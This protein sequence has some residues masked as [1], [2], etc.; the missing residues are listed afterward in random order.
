MTA[1]QDSQQK[2]LQRLVDQIERLEEEKRA[3]AADI[4]DKYKEATN[5]GFVAKQLRKIIADRRK[6]PSDRAEEEAIYDAYA[7]SLGM[8]PLGIDYSREQR[9]QEQVDR[10]AANIV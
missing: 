6:D 7:V 10:V 4:A 1:L 5:K 9:R 8:L 2:D 3:L